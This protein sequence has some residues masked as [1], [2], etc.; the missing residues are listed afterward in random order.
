MQSPD[1]QRISHIRDYCVEIANTIE[2][3]GKSFEVFS[4]DFDYQKIVYCLLSTLR[5]AFCI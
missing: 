2:R 4:G 3:Y 1:L 5:R